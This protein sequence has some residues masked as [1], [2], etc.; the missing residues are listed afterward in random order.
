G[1][2]DGVLHA[3]AAPGGTD[4]ALH[5]ADRLGVGV[6]TLEARLDQHL[7]D[8][9]QVMDLGPEK[10]DALPASDLGVEAELLRD[11]PQGNELVGGDLAAGDAW[12]DR[13]E[14]AALDV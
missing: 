4:A 8:I 10:I 11:G 14:T 3:V 9:G 7:P 2:T 12:H 6:A 5:G 1:E 13:V